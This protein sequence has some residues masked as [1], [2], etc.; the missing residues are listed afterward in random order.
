MP[1][2]DTGPTLSPPPTLKAPRSSS[3]NGNPS[4][5]RQRSHST[6]VCSSA[7]S[8]ASTQGCS[9]TMAPSSVNTG[10]NQTFHKEKS[11]RPPHVFPFPRASTPASPRM[12][13]YS[14]FAPSQIASRSNVC[15]RCVNAGFPSRVLHPGAGQTCPLFSARD[16]PDGSLNRQLI[17]NNPAWAALRTNAGANFGTGG[18]GFSPGGPPPPYPLTP[19]STAPNVNPLAAYFNRLQ[20]PTS[21]ASRLPTVAQL[22]RLEE[23]EGLTDAEIQA[24]ID[25]AAATRR[26]EALSGHQE[27]LTSL[28]AATSA[29]PPTAPPAN[30]PGG[31]ILGLAPPP[32]PAGPAGVT[33]N[34]L[35]DTIGVT[36]QSTNFSTLVRATVTAA[37]I[38]AIVLNRTGRTY[39]GLSSLTISCDLATDRNFTFTILA[40]CP[41]AQPAIIAGAD[42]RAAWTTARAIAGPS[43][44]RSVLSTAP[45]FHA[46]TRGSITF[47]P[48]TGQN[49]D[50]NLC[51]YI[52]IVGAGATANNHVGIGNINLSVGALVN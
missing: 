9:R 7:S 31:P 2:P 3:N 27:R 33:Q 21:R 39:L 34:V 40:I 22:R 18:P 49:T 35:V 19:S 47:N 26:Q 15:L 44:E 23:Y 1:P 32:P 37:Q 14:A 17:Q 30:Q 16:D 11:V 5:W 10:T 38:A 43:F 46:D 24:E 41:A 20:P 36:S 42:A 48:P 4:A 13:V 25:A 52:S 45:T 6:Q 50:I 8:N 29:V 51:I 12:S 28:G